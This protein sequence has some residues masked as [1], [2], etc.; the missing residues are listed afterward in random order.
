MTLVLQVA[1]KVKGLDRTGRIEIMTTGA[2]EVVRRKI[3]DKESLYSLQHASL[4]TGER[5]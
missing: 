2:S 3:F 5:T 1:L 4:R